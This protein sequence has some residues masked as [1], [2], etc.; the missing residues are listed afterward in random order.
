M[1][2]LIVFLFLLQVLVAFNQ[3]DKSELWRVL[4]QRSFYVD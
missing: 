2:Q 1:T 4:R 3:Q